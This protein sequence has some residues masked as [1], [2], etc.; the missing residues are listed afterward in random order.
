VSATKA[1]WVTWATAHGVTATVARRSTKD[2]LAELADGKITTEQL[3][4]LADGG[5]DEPGVRPD[6]DRL[7]QH[8]ADRIEQQSGRRPH[9]GK[10]WRQS[11]RYL[12]DIDG[13][14]EDRVH[15]AIDWCQDDEF[16][17]P[18]I[19]SMSKL[20]EKYVVLQAAAR[21]RPGTSAA[22]PLVPRSG[23]WD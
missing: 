19:L 23:L 12:L 13:L 8:L 11:A 6:V 1:V 20:R 5:R 10:L 22:D 18:N 15:A 2:H 3:G 14:C 7:C 4:E 17:R 21:R 9:I 16:W